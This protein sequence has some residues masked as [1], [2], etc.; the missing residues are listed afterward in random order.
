V[1]TSR[2]KR[3]MRRERATR[4]R[5]LSVISDPPSLRKTVSPIQAISGKGAVTAP[6][7][8]FLPLTSNF[9]HD[10][11][12]GAGVAQGAFD[13]ILRRGLVG[14]EQRDHVA[15]PPTARQFSA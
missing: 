13:T 11:I 9:R 6:L 4:S 7:W 12:P 15:A 5:V 14:C 10:D 2:A 8:V 1:R 3:W